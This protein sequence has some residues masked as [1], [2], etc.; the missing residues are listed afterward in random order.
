[1]FDRKVVNDIGEAVSEWAKKNEDRFASERKEFATE[2]GIPIK[3]L[4][5]PADLDQR[6]FDYMRDSGLP[7]EFPY[8]RGNSPVGYRGKLWG[9]TAYGGKGTPE[10]S[11]ALWKAQLEAGADTISVAYDLPT[12]LGFDPDSGKAGGEVGRVGISMVSQRDWETAWE[13]IDFSKVGVYQVLNAPAIFGLANHIALAGSRGISVDKLRGMQQNDVL[14]EYMARGNY[15]FPPSQSIRLIG[16]ILTYVG[17]NM[18]RY[19]ATTVCGVHQSERGANNINELAL[20]MINA[21]TYLQAAVDRGVDIDSVAP[22]VM[23]FPGCDHFVFF[24]EIAKLRA[25]RRMWA[26]IMR[27]RFKAKKPESLQC[28]IYVAEGGMGLHRE[29][30]LN[31]VGR[32][33]LATLAAALAGVELID[34]R[35]YDEQFGIPTTEAQV[36]SIRMQNV[37]AYETGVD[38]TVDPLGGSYF[39]ES[40]T[41][42]TEERAWKVIEDIERQG[43]IVRCIETGYVQRLIA[44]DAYEWQK[45]FE[46]DEI[47]RV[48]V[49]VFRSTDGEAEKPIRVYRSNPAIEKQRVEAVQAMR[50]ARDNDKVRRCLDELTALAREPASGANNLVPAVIESVKAYATVGEVADALRK[51][52]G[53]FREPAIS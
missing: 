23:F 35:S 50:K 32:I 37:V 46:S 20:M 11:N 30:Y 49:N 33:G 6:G 44:R 36:N 27:D 18:P 16:D 28:R 39:V 29:Q 17:S 43:G 1:M 15:I 26:K 48:G 40:L 4:Y 22:G 45:R 47:K 21:T 52:F 19:Q 38:A 42:E 7:G 34:T 53:E 2:S 25:M 13:G 31:N 5:T 41:C 8:L 51:V 14:K 10:E 24:E 9:I 12:Q 3:R